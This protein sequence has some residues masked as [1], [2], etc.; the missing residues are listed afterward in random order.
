MPTSASRPATTTAA[1]LDSV[2][3]IYGTFAALRNVST[4]FPS[5]TCTVI[6]GE[7]GAGKSTLLRIV[8]GLI[9]PTRGSVTVFAQSSP[10]QQ[11]HRMAYMSHSPMLYD[12]LTAMENLNYFASLHRDDGCA[13][14]GSPEMAL[15]AVGLD[16]ALTRPVGQYSQGMRQRTSLAR[17]L[18]T[19]P[20]LLLLDEPFSN[21]DA[22]SSQHMVELLADFRTWPLAGGGS[23]TIL[24]TTHLAHLAHPIADRTLTLRNGQILESLGEPT[25]LHEAK[26]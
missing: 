17:V 26:A 22:A 25:S 12:E 3:K 15:R 21:L 2:S 14:V 7:N 1:Q 8:A 9:T 11:R 13:C 23:R 24:I 19:D 10:H 5:G 16:P 20:E 18:Q 4:T 6:L